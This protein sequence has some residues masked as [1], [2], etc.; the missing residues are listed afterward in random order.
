MVIRSLSVGLGQLA[1]ITPA[2]G[3]TPN[4]EVKIQVTDG[5]S[6]IEKDDDDYSSGTY[7]HK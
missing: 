4:H 1:R 2:V 6:G 7:T 3:P 5:V